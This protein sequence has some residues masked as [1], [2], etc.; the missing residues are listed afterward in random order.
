MQKMEAK[1][2]EQQTALDALERELA[3]AKKGKPFEGGK[4]RAPE[5]CAPTPAKPP[6]LL[7]PP[8][9]CAILPRSENSTWALRCCC[10][11]RTLHKL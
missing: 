2:L 6:V 3:A 5:S 10:R 9:R 8:S 11:H 7:L 1:L 4:A